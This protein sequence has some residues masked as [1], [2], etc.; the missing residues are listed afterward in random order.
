MFSQGPEMHSCMY[1]DGRILIGVMVLSQRPK[2]PDRN[3]V[4]LFICK[5][6]SRLI[7]RGRLMNVLMLRINEQVDVVTC[8]GVVPRLTVELRR[9]TDS[10]DHLSPN[11]EVTHVK[12]HLQFTSVHSHD[13]D[14]YDNG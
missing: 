14:V 13:Q 6:V 3:L 5:L 9:F 7:S 2:K 8:D 12:D 1:D 11:L 10:C 4:T